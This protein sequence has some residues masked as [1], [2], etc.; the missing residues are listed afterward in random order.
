MRTSVALLAAL[1]IALGACD[2]NHASGSASP[3]TATPAPRPTPAA[4]PTP[5]PTPTPPPAPSRPATGIHWMNA[6][7][8][9]QDATQTI[10]ASMAAEKAAG[11]KLIVYVGATWC[12]PCQHFHHAV[13]QGQ[14][15]AA[16]PQLSI[17]AFDMDRDAQALMAAGYHSKLIPLFAL[18]GDDGMASGKQIEGSVKGDNAVSEITPRLRKLL[19]G[20]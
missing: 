2:E 3:T 13:E 4:A 10:Q 15:D 1:G 16:F 9:L 19:G 5:A 20:G 11:R 18:P 17:L 8:G 14:L 7:G 12:E 6:P